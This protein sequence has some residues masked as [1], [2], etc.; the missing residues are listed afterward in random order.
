MLTDCF[1]TILTDQILIF[2]GANKEKLQKL[3]GDI[4]LNTLASSPTTSDTIVLFQRAASDKTL[5]HHTLYNG[6]QN[7]ASLNTR[8][9][10]EIRQ[11]R[12]MSGCSYHF[13]LRCCQ[14]RTVKR[15]ILENSST[16][17]EKGND[18]GSKR[19]FTMK[20]REKISQK[21]SQDKYS[22]VY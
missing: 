11:G 16:L 12:E 21:R 13:S 17:T 7:K 10:T 19:C 18:E 4:S 3:T 2:T 15:S 14:I 6:S 20:M 1:C 8:E 9:R 22:R 5:I